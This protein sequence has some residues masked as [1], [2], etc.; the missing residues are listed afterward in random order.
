MKRIILLTFFS[1]LT[2]TVCQAQTSDTTQTKPLS[3]IVI[4][5]RISILIG[6]NYRSNHFAEIGIAKDDRCMISYFDFGSTHYLATEIKLDNKTIIGPKIG[7]WTYIEPL[8]IGANLIYYTDF[9]ESSLRFR[10]EV[11]LG[12]N[13][14]KIV[15]GYN[16]PLSNRNFEGINKHNFGFAFLIP[17]KTFRNK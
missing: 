15:Y 7:T 5:E 11:G 13:H 4:R 6:Y 8:G 9:N 17:V 2:F 12:F 14:L 3:G 1:F 10:P 16:L